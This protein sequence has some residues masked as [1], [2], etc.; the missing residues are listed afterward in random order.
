MQCTGCGNQL[1]DGATRCVVCGTP[2]LPPP[3]VGAEPVAFRYDKVPSR[4]PTVFKL[5]GVAAA[6]AVI[7][8][9]ISPILTDVKGEVDDSTGPAAAATTVASVDTLAPIAADTAATAPTEV[10]ATAGPVGDPGSNIAG[11]DRRRV[12]CTAR[13]STDSLGNPIDFK[14]ENTID[15][16]LG[17]AWRCGGDGAGVTITYTLPGPG[18][19]ERRGRRPRVRRRG[20]PQRRR[21][22]H[23]EP[24][25]RLGPLGVPRPATPTVATVDQTFQDARL[26]QTIAGRPGSSGAR[27]FA[28]RSSPPLLPASRDFVALSEVR[29]GPGSKT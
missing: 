5:V 16:D 1:P 25:G 21:P 24:P 18:Q 15:G 8:F 3:P 17:T 29:L 4:W 9:A 22:L 23:P 28:S 7:V 13:G 12:S 26:L 6:I 2:A 19:R 14:P 20:S 11:L 27:R 10:P